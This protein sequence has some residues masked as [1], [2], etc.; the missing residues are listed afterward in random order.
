ML[1]FFVHNAI[2]P[3]MRH[4]NPK[5]RLCDLGIAYTMVGTLYV[6]VG[7]AG[8][9]V[10]PKFSTCF[11]EILS[12][13][14]QSFIAL[15]PPSDV[16][17]FMANCALFMQ[18][19]TVFPILLVIIRSEVFGLI[20]FKKY[21]PYYTVALVST[22]CMAVTTSFAIW[23]PKVGEVLRFTGAGGGLLIVF[24]IPCLID[25]IALMERS[26]SGPVDQH[27]KEVTHKNDRGYARVNRSPLSESGRT[28]RRHQNSSMTSYDLKEG[29]WQTNSTKRCCRLTVNILLVSMAAG[30]LALQFIE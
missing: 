1:A 24:I 12:S 14:C 28:E 22:A 27:I 2:H 15:F 29:L 3:I 21:P 19:F 17:A 6:V 13:S 9:L 8:A 10:L 18:L 7:F 25:S 26:K 5:T 23:Y 16:L 4:S 20:G 30:V 11:P